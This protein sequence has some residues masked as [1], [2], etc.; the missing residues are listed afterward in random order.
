MG[1]NEQTSKRKT[2]SKEGKR[3][4]LQMESKKSQKYDRNVQGWEGKA[5]KRNKTTQARTK[6]KVQIGKEYTPGWTVRHAG[7][8][9]PAASQRKTPRGDP[10]QGRKLAT[11]ISKP[12]SVIQHCHFF[13]VLLF[14]W[15]FR[16][17]ILGFPGF[18]LG[19][20]I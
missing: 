9:L 20:R 5:P 12:P 6:E 13:V 7:V 3:K 14:F 19:R 15:S 18:A 8:S 10:L 11:S 4:K 1:I 16:V 17:V 2:N